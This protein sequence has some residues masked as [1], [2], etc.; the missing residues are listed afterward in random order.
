MNISK[1][2]KNIRR[3]NNTLIKGNFKKKIPIKYNFPKIE[4][5]LINVYNKIN[6]NIKLNNTIYNNNINKTK[7]NISFIKNLNVFSNYIKENIND[8]IK[9][10]IFELKKIH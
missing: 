1:N 5:D 7:V 3:K 10:R 4:N 6:C 8:V 2:T 9:H